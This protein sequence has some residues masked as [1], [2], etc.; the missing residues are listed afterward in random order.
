VLGLL[1]YWQKMKKRSLA[2]FVLGAITLLSMGFRTPE[3][4]SEYTGDSDVKIVK[5]TVTN[6]DSD[7]FWDYLT[8]GLEGFNPN[9][10]EITLVEILDSDG[11]LIS[12]INTLFTTGKEDDITWFQTDMNELGIH[13]DFY[14]EVHIGQRSRPGSDQILPSALDKSPPAAPNDPEETILIVKYP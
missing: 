11:N 8:F 2:L 1:K 3:I 13:K 4:G 7:R 14:L 12:R 9:K 10:Q 5:G 6:S